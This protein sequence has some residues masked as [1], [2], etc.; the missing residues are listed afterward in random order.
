MNQVAEHPDK[1]VVEQNLCFSE[2]KEDKVKMQQIE[3]F[4]LTFF[5]SRKL[6]LKKSDWLLALTGAYCVISVMM[7]LLCMKPMS[8]GTNFIWMDGGLLIS[9]I[10]FLISNVI[11]E[12]YGKREAIV[13]AGIATIIAFM[14]SIIAALE[15][16]LPTL[17][18]Y[19]A[20]AEHF[21]N[22]FS[23]GPRTITS[24][25]IAFFLGNLINVEII[26][27]LRNK[28]K[29]LNNDNTKR[30][31]FRAVLSTIVGQF[32]DNAMFQIFAFAPIGISIFEMQWKDIGSAIAMSTIVETIIESFFIGFVTIPLTRYLKKLN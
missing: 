17:P 29:T 28:A 24:S 4:C 26:D 32:A 9:W 16:F 5:S 19:N 7:N 25:A 22:I 11:T 15:V 30:F 10:V 23:N 12:V 31:N 2:P 14:M 27:R 8:F 13:V 20:Q 1:T 6:R 18:Q 3:S 21:A